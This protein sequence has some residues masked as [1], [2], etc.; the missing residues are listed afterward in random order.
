[1]QLLVP[2]PLAATTW[3]QGDWNGDLVFDSNDFVVAFIDGYYE[4]PDPF[5]GNGGLA[6]VPEPSG[7]VLL[8]LGMLGLIDRRSRLRR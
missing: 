4:Q 8:L 5:R 7:L 2:Q 1:L 3:T 6:S